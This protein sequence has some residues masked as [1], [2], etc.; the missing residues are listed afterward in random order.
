MAEMKRLET[1]KYKPENLK[2]RSFRLG[3]RNFINKYSGQDALIEQYHA[4]VRTIA[5]ASDE[6]KSGAFKKRALDALQAVQGGEWVTDGVV[7]WEQGGFNPYKNFQKK[8]L[9][10]KIAQLNA[11]I[12]E[13]G[14][15]GR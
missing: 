1:P 8:E 13:L 6:S 9:R 5:T 12:Q 7:A 2:V 3:V 14:I 10:Q 11:V 4:A 15:N